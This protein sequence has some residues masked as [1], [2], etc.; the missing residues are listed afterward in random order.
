M[1]AKP[2][3]EVLVEIPKLNKVRVII[4]KANS[5]L[6]QKEP[7]NISIMGRTM[8]EWVKLSCSTYATKV[9]DYDIKDDLLSRV[10]D[11]VEDED[12]TVVLFSDTPLIK[13][14][15][16]DDVVDYAI[17][18]GIDVCKLQRGYVFKSEF[19]KN[20]KEITTTTTPNFFDE[21]DFIVVNNFQ[22]LALVEETIRKRILMA[23]LKNGVRILDLDSVS[24]DTM[25]TIRE[26]V[27][28]YPNNRIYGTC[29]IE[30]N[31]VLEPNNV[32]F[33][34]VIGENSK[35]ISSVIRNS[36]I[37]K[38]SKIGP[39]KNVNNKKS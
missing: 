3:T 31:V 1:I 4:L 7:Y 10:K 20:A 14:K 28:I 33:S 35:I 2:E 36:K 17:T 22:N 39:F 26:G 13:R 18:K 21:E 37:E 25:T 27:V 32:I 23:H 34:S 24:I 38:D 12:Y 19:L 16:I 29:I 9:V 11:F 5:F 6:G 15:T 8:L 30:K